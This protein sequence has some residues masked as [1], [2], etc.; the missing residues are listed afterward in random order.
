[1]ARHRR[2]R[3]YDDDDRPRRAKR[4]RESKGRP[5]PLLVAAGAVLAVA[6]V[7]VVVV[8]RHRSSS[9]TTSQTPPDS[10][11]KSPPPET[12]GT[13]STTP[14]SAPLPA[15]L[16]FSKEPKLPRDVNDFAGP[17]AEFENVPGELISGQRTLAAP[18]V[19]RRRRE[20][21]SPGGIRFLRDFPRIREFPPPLSRLESYSG[22]E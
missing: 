21:C 2:T 7:V 16:T 4:H 12:P 11:A 1:M 20:T 5:L 14:K 6:V 17:W 10:T 15:V 8:V 18:R 3:E 13:A 9:T 19:D 22:S